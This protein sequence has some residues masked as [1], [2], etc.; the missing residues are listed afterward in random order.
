VIG[1]TSQAPATA[2]HVVGEPVPS[3]CYVHDVCRI[4]R[5][6]RSTFERQYAAKQL[7]LVELERIGRPRR[8]TGESV[9][10]ELLRTRWSRQGG[11]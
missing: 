1:A 10:Q 8:F 6:S 2:P 3:I 4:L 7:R 9:H 5:I 11:R